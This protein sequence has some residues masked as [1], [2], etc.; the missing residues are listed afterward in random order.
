MIKFDV[1]SFFCECI[2]LFCTHRHSVTTLINS[3]IYIYVNMCQNCNDF[4]GLFLTR[5]SLP[6]S[7]VTKNFSELKLGSHV[8]CWSETST[9]CV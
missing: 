9:E 4:V 8:F 5:C 7:Q 6:R 2:K 3:H 1:I